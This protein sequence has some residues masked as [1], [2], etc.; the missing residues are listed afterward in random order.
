MPWCLIHRITGV[1]PGVSVA[2]KIALRS[3]DHHGISITLAYSSSNI[4]DILTITGNFLLC[5]SDFIIPWCLT[6]RSTGVPPS[7]SVALKIALR[8]L[9]H[10]GITITLA[11]AS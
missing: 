1:P 7:V 10:H 8:S 6:H 4:S 5:A 2:L 3:L 9:E 11:Y